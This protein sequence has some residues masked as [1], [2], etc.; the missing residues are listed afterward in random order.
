M[1][2][3]KTSFN[4]DDQFENTGISIRDIVTGK[5]SKSTTH[6]TVKDDTLIKF[7]SFNHELYHYIDIVDNPNMMVLQHYNP[8][9]N[10]NYV[11]NPQYNKDR[12]FLLVELNDIPKIISEH[13]NF[14]KYNLVLAGGFF[15]SLLMRQ[16]IN[17]FDLYFTNPISLYNMLEQVENFIIHL[18][19]LTEFKIE[20][21]VTT[22]TMF[23]ILV[24]YNNTLL[25][26]QIILKS[27]CN[28]AYLLNTFDLSV[29]QI[30]Y[31][32]DSFYATVPAFFSIKTGLIPIELYRARKAF[33]NRII[34]YYGRGFGLILYS[35]TPLNITTKSFK[36]GKYIKVKYNSY[37]DKS[38]IP[39]LKYSGHKNYD[40]GGILEGINLL[41]DNEIVNYNKHV[42]ES[43]QIYIVTKTKETEISY[44]K[45][46]VINNYNKL[47]KQLEEIDTEIKLDL[48]N[49]SYKDMVINNITN[50]MNKV[51]KYYY[52]LKYNPNTNDLVKLKFNACS[53][54]TITKAYMKV[55]SNNIE[56]S[57]NIN[58]LLDMYGE[59]I[60]LT[61]EDFYH[62]PID[63]FN[64]VNNVNVD[65]IDTNNVN[66]D[67]NNN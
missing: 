25:K 15:S 43:R 49:R 55:G 23:T 14:K 41:D 6:Y 7:N 34:K 40:S 1:N 64:S 56:L 47:M 12:N 36:L 62:L 67:F 5:Y 46:P 27:H 66:D 17:D 30:A 48:Q 8:E 24:T 33:E 51:I 54:V 42:L 57:F 61:D 37:Y 16:P 20:R 10:L 4:I 53:D 28:I 52:D 31:D 22:R 44:G 50:S 60:Y 13:I 18:R 59:K 19:S 35:D 45:L 2:I 3:G 38:Y 26:F 21:I 11:I 29:C 32:G 9:G 63:S 65:F 58:M 39:F